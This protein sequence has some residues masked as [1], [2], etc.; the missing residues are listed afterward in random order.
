MAST[1]R[2]TPTRTI[3]GPAVKCSLDL[4][5]AASADEVLLAVEITTNLVAFG[6]LL[7]RE[8]VAIYPNGAVFEQLELGEAS[9]GNDVFET[10][11]DSGL[12]DLNAWDAILRLRR[13]VQ[14]VHRLSYRNPMDNAFKVSD[15]G[16]N[17]IA[18][19][20]RLILF[21]PAIRRQ[22]RAKAAQAE[23]DLR[24]RKAALEAEIEARIAGYEKEHVELRILKAK[25][26]AEQLKNEKRS[27]DLEFQARIA[28]IHSTRDQIRN[29]KKQRYHL[30]LAI[31]V[32]AARDQLSQDNPQLRLKDWDIG[33]VA[34]SLDDNTESLVNGARK[35]NMAVEV[36]D[37]DE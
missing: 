25:F 10:N 33:D 13:S 21:A 16:A 23:I 9:R 29:L 26:D 27:F 2:Y 5:P 30:P 7:C 6:A 1:T 22:E 20:I 15:T 18:E 19:I 14:T 3:A 11:P 31:D 8:N 36:E 32:V 24:V 17:G 37:D 12:N 34:A 28:E 4:G 35:L